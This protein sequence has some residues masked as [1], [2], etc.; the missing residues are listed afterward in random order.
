MMDRTGASE[1]D[2]EE[3]EE[4][5]EEGGDMLICILY[6]SRGSQEEISPSEEEKDL[7]SHQRWWMDATCSVWSFSAAS[8]IWYPTLS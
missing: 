1:R 4:V 6:P 7:W 3:E 5:E 8:H 2:E